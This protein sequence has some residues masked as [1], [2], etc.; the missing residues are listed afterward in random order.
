[1]NGPINCAAACLLALA[2]AA[3]PLQSHRLV[4]RADQMVYPVAAPPGPGH[5]RL[6]IDPRRPPVLCRFALS[7]P[8][9]PGRYE[10]SVDSHDAARN[11]FVFS[12]PAPGGKCSFVISARAQARYAFV[13]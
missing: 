8:L 1:M 4:L 11:T 12:I 3:A 13:S 7:P 6:V 9:P 5:L 10:I 2:A